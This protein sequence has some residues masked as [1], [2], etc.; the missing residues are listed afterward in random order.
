MAI[1]VMHILAGSG[2]RVILGKAFG[3]TSTYLHLSI[4]VAAGVFLPLLAVKIIEKWRIPYVFSA[5]IS[6]IALRSKI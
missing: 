6:R 1:Y 3:I 2:V 4:G 5:P